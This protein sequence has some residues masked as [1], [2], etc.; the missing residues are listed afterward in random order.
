MVGFDIIFPFVLLLL[1]LGCVSGF[2]AGLL[3]VGGGIVLVPGLFYILT[4]MQEYTDFD[5]DRIMHICVGTSLAVIVPTGF[6]S[7]WSHYKRGAVDFDLVCQIGLGIVI[8]V[9]FSTFLAGFLDGF[10]LKILFACA[11][12][13]FATLLVFNRRK[14]SDA[15]SVGA[16]DDVVSRRVRAFVHKIA[17]FFIGAISTLI[18]IGGATLSVPYMTMR[19]IAIHR[20]IGTASALG[21][22]ISVPASIGFVVIG[23]WQSGLPPFSLGYVNVLA[24]ACIIPASVMIAPIGARVAHHMRV[25]PLKIGFAIF[26][27]FV[28]VNMWR[29]I[30]TG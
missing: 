7:A 25:R 2:L 6:S 28:A 3:G 18:G 30:L 23:F 8:G 12:P 13:I 19:G 1:A 20:A 29:Q 24:W 17:G 22:V 14:N 16:G 9:L 11:L 27:M 26:M 21:L 5:T 10:V 15:S 4:M